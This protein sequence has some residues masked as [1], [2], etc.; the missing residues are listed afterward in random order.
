MDT[1]QNQSQQQVVISRK[2]YN[3]LLALKDDYQYLL[4]QMAE[5]KRMLFG[6]K[7]ERFVPATS[8]GIQLDL[9]AP[10]TDN[11]AIGEQPV[12]ESVS[13]QREKTRKKSVRSALPSHLRREQE[14]IEPENIP[15]GAVRIGQTVTEILEYKPAEVYVRAIIRPKYVVPG[16]EGTGCVMVASLPCLPLI[17]ANAGSGLLAYICVSKLIDHLPFY[18]LAQIFKRDKIPLPEST[19]KGWFA[20]V[21]RLLEPLMKPYSKKYSKAVTFRQMNLL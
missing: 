17:R 6:S 9:F 7:S 19:I 21:C 10:P 14:I 18:R 5:L 3:D 15:E 20:A 12:K 11:P 13:Y 1:K 4:F 8:D 16:S 2:E